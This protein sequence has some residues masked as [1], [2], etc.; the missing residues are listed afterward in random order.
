MQ[1]SDGS[2]LR[3]EVLARWQDFVGTGEF[4][5]AVEQ[6]IGWLRDK[7]RATLR[8]AL[9]AA[10]R[11]RLD[12]SRSVR[13]R[14]GT[15]LADRAIGRA[16]RAKLGGRIRARGHEAAE[17]VGYLAAEGGVVVEDDGVVEGDDVSQRGEIGGQAQDVVDDDE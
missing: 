6:R 12:G 16:V 5:R 8:G 3:G 4:M 11:Y 13:D 15:A 2:L 7:L 10:E 17:G 9:A 1:T 14:L